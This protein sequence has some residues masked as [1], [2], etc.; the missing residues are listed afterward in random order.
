MRERERQTKRETYREREHIIRETYRERDIHRE[1]ERWRETDKER[2]RERG[3]FCQ[4]IS[5]GVKKNKNVT[6]IK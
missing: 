6:E 2:K 3:I 4:V 5:E 1:R